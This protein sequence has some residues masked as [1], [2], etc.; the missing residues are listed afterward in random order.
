MKRIL[1]MYIVSVISVTCAY[2]DVTY[3][4]ID[5]DGRNDGTS[6]KDAFRDLQKALADVEFGDEVWVAQ[7]TYYPTLT[8]DREMTFLL[9]DGV[10]VYGGFSGT[11]KRRSDRDWEEYTTV[12]SGNIGKPRERTDNSYRV[13]SI[14][15][16]GPETTLDG[17][18][19]TAAYNDRQEEAS[20]G[21]GIYNVNGNLQIANCVIIENFASG[22]GVWNEGGNPVFTNCAFTLNEHGAVINSTGNPSF[23]GCSFN[24]NISKGKGAAY[25]GG[26]QWQNAVFVSCKFRGNQS[27]GRGGAYFGRG[28]PLFESCTF[29]DNRAEATG[30]RSTYPTAM[31]V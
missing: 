3:V 27:G 10:G 21:G 19:I 29:L 5:A 23:V 9:T 7:G 8:R 6:W 12:L 4:D 18:T 14:L 28:T 2:G 26:S 1:R 17:F 20:R 24:E 22:G 11:E 25:N 31:R 15:G 30:E 16:A 13:V